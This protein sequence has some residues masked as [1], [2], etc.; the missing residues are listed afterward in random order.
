MLFM[1]FRYGLIYRIYDI[2]S[3]QLC[4]KIINNIFMHFCSYTKVFRIYFLNLH[5]ITALPTQCT[6]IIFKKE[7]IQYDNYMLHVVLFSY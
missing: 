3:I 6:K 4:F 7:H 5:F 1:M 2:P